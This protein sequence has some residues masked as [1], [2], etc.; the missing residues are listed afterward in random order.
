MAEILSGSIDLSKIDKSKIKEVV[1]KDGTK[2][3][4]YDVSIFIKNE[5]DQYNN[6]A[7]ISQSQTKEER[8]S[9]IPQIYL[10]NLKRTWSAKPPKLEESNTSNT[11]KGDDLPF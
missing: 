3:L 1:K 9:K 4:Y 5:Q 11:D 8:E 7:S 10:G 6:I 2:A